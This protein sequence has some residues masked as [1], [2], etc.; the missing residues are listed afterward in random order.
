MPVCSRTGTLFIAPSIC[1]MNTSQSRS[2]KLNANLSDT[3][4]EKKQHKTNKKHKHK[5]LFPDLH[6]NAIRCFPLAFLFTVLESKCRQW[7]KITLHYNQSTCCCLSNRFFPSRKSTSVKSDFTI[8]VQAWFCSQSFPQ[9]Q[10]NV[11]FHSYYLWSSVEVIP[12][13]PRLYQLY[14]SDIPPNILALIWSSLNSYWTLLHRGERQV[15]LVSET[16]MISSKNSSVICVTL[17]VCRLTNTKRASATVQCLLKD[18]WSNDSC[19]PVNKASKLHD[20]QC[21]DTQLDC[22]ACRIGFL[23]VLEPHSDPLHLSQT[24]DP[25]RLHSVGFF[26][27]VHLPANSSCLYLLFLYP[28]TSGHQSNTQLQ[29]KNKRSCFCTKNLKCETTEE[30]T[31]AHEKD[32]VIKSLSQA[33]E[34]SNSPL[35]K[36]QTKALNHLDY[37]NITYYRVFDDTCVST[38]CS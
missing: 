16:F 2:N 21:S 10:W 22:L 7:V 35:V 30:S 28:S 19:F 20:A 4:R 32:K 12:P 37:I 23:F 36:T 29:N 18:A 17:E 27:S 5:P 26:Y 6:I 33:R 11:A 31:H 34:K 9:S 14:Q 24:I 8:W 1:C 25:A 13:P 3:W 15:P 38:V